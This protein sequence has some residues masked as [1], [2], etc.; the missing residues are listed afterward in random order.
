V[1]DL[2]PFLDHFRELGADPVNLEADV[3]HEMVARLSDGG[4]RLGIWAVRSRVTFES[5]DVGGQ[6][7]DIEIGAHEQR[8]RET[9]I[10]HDM[11]AID[12][13]ERLQ[14]LGAEDHDGI[15]AFGEL[16]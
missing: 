10:G 11:H 7:L 2:K 4:A 8:L 13:L 15:S 12:G 6:C 5:R 16:A 14:N 3:R 9:A 1:E